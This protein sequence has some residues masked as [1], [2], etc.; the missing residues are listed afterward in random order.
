MD[1]GHAMTD[2]E[3]PMTR[4]SLKPTAVSGKER[5]MPSRNPTFGVSAII[6]DGFIVLRLP[7]ISEDKRKK[8]STG[9]SI[10]YANTY[11]PKIVRQ[12][13][14]DELVPVTVDGV[15]LRIIASAY[16]SIPKDAAKTVDS[17]PHETLEKE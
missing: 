5:K 3:K 2:R 6:E 15:P 9:K 8:S 16:L 10:L 7:I 11:G 12:R 14:D 13:V 17:Q 1:K 4:I